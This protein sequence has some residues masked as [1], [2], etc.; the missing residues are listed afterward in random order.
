MSRIT[1]LQWCEVQI[2][3]DERINNSL[4]DGIVSIDINVD[5]F[6]LI[7]ISSDG[8]LLERKVIK[9]NLII[10]SSNQA[11]KEI[12]KAV[13]EVFKY[14]EERHKPLGR[15]DLKNIQFKSTGDKKKNKTL[16]QFAYDKIINALDKNF[17]NTYALAQ[18]KHY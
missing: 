2:N 12:E 1:P 4:V 3:N 16:T 7:N 10:L 15:E 6:A 8:N 9:F 18:V 17:S 13:N 14:C 11:I 5:N